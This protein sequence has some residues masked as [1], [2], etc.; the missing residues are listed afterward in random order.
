MAENNP[1]LPL[2]TTQRVLQMDVFGDIY[3]QRTINRFYYI[4][5][6][7]ANPSPN[8]TDA[9]VEMWEGLNDPW[10]A[11]VSEDWTITGIVA[12]DVTVYGLAPKVVLAAALTAPKAGALGP[13]VPPADAVCIKRTTA[14]A[15]KKAR[16]RVFIA[17]LAEDDH[18]DGHLTAGAVTRFGALAVAVLLPFNVAGVGYAAAQAFWQHS[19][20]DTVL[21]RAGGLVDAEADAVLRTQR[22][23]QLGRGV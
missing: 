8:L 6:G 2:I 9:A 1:D 13:G 23:R 3:G 10:C 11:A 15:G 16:G 20:P 21:V 18:E 14:F 19:P 5:P 22:R 4:S 17:G 7:P 12:R